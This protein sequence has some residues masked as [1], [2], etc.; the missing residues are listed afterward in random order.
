M[1][2]NDK[3]TDGVDLNTSIESLMDMISE[4]RDRLD[5]QE[6]LASD[7][8]A[9]ILQG[10]GPEVGLDAFQVSPYSR[11]SWARAENPFGFAPTAG[12]QGRVA[13]GGGRPF[14]VQE[15]PQMMEEAGN[16][17]ANL[18]ASGGLIKDMI[19]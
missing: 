8:A 11:A 14:P 5:K 12:G 1:A 19:G 18:L 7:P 16:L 3:A 2:E 9:S 6:G 4:L 15:G 17:I 13:F 10:Q